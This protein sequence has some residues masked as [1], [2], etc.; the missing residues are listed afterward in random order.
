MFMAILFSWLC[1]WS[2]AA[3]AQTDWAS[4]G[5]D[6]G[7]MRFSTL[8]EI[9]RAN[10][11]RLRAAWT[12][13]TGGQS[14]QDRFPMQCTP[15][16]IGGVM[17]LTGP[18]LTLFA[19]DAATGRERWRFDPKR[20]AKRA[21]LGN[22]GVAYWSEGKKNGARRIV[23]ATTDGRLFSLDAE[24]G[25]P[26]Q[27]FGSKGIVNLR[28]AQSY[29]WGPDFARSESGA[30]ESSGDELSIFRLVPTGFAAEY[31]QAIGTDG[32]EI[33]AAK[34]GRLFLGLP[35]DGVLIVNTTNPARPTPAGFVRTLGS[36]TEVTVVPEAEEAFVAAGHYGVYRLDLDD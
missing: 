16:V 23:L 27:A 26:D 20:E 11:G 35:G 9:D 28:E 2:S 31:H 32:A 29:R 4:V 21:Y 12:F 13:R 22:R 33:L 25:T 36:T 1:L 5:N 15:V 19:L 18:N 34:A 7:A 30:V 6:T 24:T 8:A 17:Y 10:V 3:L 14:D